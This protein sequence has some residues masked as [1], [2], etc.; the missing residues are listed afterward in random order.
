MASTKELRRRIRSIKTTAQ[1]TR[2]MQ[3]VAT[4][5]MRKSQ[6]QTLSARSYSLVLSEILKELVGKIHLTAHPLLVKREVRHATILLITPDKGL[7]GALNANLFRHIAASEQVDSLQNTPL[8]FIAVGK[9]GRQYLAKRKQ[10]LTLDFASMVQVD[11]AFA[12]TIAK[13]VVGGFTKGTTDA[14]FGI[15]AHFESTLKQSAR[16]LQILPIERFFLPNAEMKTKDLTQATSSPSDYLIEPDPDWVLE[17]ILPHYVEF[18]IYQI[19]LEA[20]ASEH[21]A[22][23]VA[24]KNATDNAIELAEDLTFTLNSVRQ[25]AIT[26]DILDIA[27]AAS[28][29]A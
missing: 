19:L 7:C 22:R 12:R 15:Y 9:K 4:S 27:T 3:M 2:A 16:T 17:N 29:L 18:A 20:V 28:A 26:R 25:D 10:N 13:T 1:I 5:K 11:F 14:V 23:M 6:D 8:S 21:S 24:M